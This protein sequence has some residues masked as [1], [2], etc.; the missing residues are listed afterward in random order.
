MHTC[1]SR[2]SPV[3]PSPKNAHAQ[4]IFINLSIAYAYY[5]HSYMYTVNCLLPLSFQVTY[6]NY[7]SVPPSLYFPDTTISLLH[8]LES[9]MGF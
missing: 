2:P 4:G 6:F 8:A 3:S 9:R 5:V 7:T 1:V